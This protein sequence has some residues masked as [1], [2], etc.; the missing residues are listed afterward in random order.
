MELTPTFRKKNLIFKPAFKKEAL[1]PP[2]HG[3]Q[4]EESRSP[5]LVEVKEESLFVA[6]SSFTSW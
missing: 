3:P 4:Q 6:E 1:S 5:K 2:S